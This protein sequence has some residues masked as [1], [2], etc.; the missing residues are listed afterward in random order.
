M[1]EDEEDCPELVP[2]PGTRFST[3]VKPVVLSSTTFQRN[4]FSFIKCFERSLP[5]LKK[6]EVLKYSSIIARYEGLL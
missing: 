3:V 2:A 1:S 4:L 6:A 5:S